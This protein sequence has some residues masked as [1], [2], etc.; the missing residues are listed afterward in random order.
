LATTPSARASTTN[1]VAAFM[2]VARDNSSGCNRHVLGPRSYVPMSMPWVCIVALYRG[3]QANRIPAKEMLKVSASAC[4][5]PLLLLPGPRRRLPPSPMWGSCCSLPVH[6]AP[7]SGPPILFHFYCCLF[8][9]PSALP[10]F[11]FLSCAPCAHW[12]LSRPGAVAPPWLILGL[13][14]GLCHAFLRG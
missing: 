4:T 9:F 6:A 14:R 5:Q 12:G 7:M 2:Y 8:F 11:S 13:P 1:T 3:R 10:A